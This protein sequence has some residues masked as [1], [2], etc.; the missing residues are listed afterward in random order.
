MKFL[1]G[2]IV[3]VLVFL[4]GVLVGRFSMSVMP[5]PLPQESEEAIQQNPASTMSTSSVVTENSE[6]LLEQEV[7]RFSVADLPAAQQTVLRTFGV[8]SEE[9]IIT[10]AMYEC[11][12]AKLTVDKLEAIKN[13][14]APSF[15]ES[16]VLVGCYTSN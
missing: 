1:F 2:L 11:I 6:P 14:A 12:T 16:V 3:I 4:L 8:N 15:T 5:T 13:G 9:I 10:Q 7:F